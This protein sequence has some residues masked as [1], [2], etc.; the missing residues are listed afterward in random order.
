MTKKYQKS[1]FIFRR[2]LRLDDNTALL[3][4]T[5]Q[6]QKII[7]IFIYDPQQITNKNKY[8]SKNALQFMFKSITD[9]KKQLHNRKGKLYELYGISDKVIEDVIKQ[10]K[11]DAIFFN[12]DYTPFSKRRDEKIE[13]LCK[14]YHIDC[15]SFHDELINNP[16]EIFTKQ[17][18]PYTI[19]TPYFK[20]AS[21]L[22]IKKPQIFP[23]IFFVHEPIE[24][25]YKNIPSIKIIKN[26]NIA[27][28]GGRKESQKIVK[29]IKKFKN[30]NKERNFPALDATT[31]L[32]AHNKFGTSSI[33]EIYYAIKENLG[34]DND[35]IQE[36][37][38]RDFFT[39]IADHFPHV[40]K[41]PFKE[42]YKKIKW[43]NN[44]TWFKNWCNGT[45]GFP[46]VDAGMRELNQTGFMHNRVRMIVAS[47]LC[48]HL[49]IDWRW[50]EKYF[51]QKLLDYELSSNNGN[52]QWAAGTGCDAAPFFRI[53]NPWTQQKKFDPDREYIRKWV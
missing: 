47:F 8:L 18:K 31:K 1:L 20:A 37:Y 52:W 50:G 7:P 12:K 3:E 49:L 25:S 44:R 28:R 53:F 27:E 35:L 41:G 46:I 21:K 34:L 43:K 10:N 23:K 13:K 32:S 42:K 26:N 39:Y 17:V 14:K 40:F 4:A 5:K 51:A 11:I 19:F 33:R 36:L 6:S 45:T 30:Y 9:L 48:K 24:S 15:N 2:D 38:W 22:S 16:E 29:N